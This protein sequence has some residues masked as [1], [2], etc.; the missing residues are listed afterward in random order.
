MSATVITATL[1][2]PRGSKGDV[3]TI[4]CGNCGGNHATVADVRACFARGPGAAMAADDAVPLPPDPG[5][6]VVDDDDPPP[7]DAQPARARALGGTPTTQNRPGSP[8]SAPS[9][10]ATPSRPGATRPAAPAPSRPQP[11]P[12]PARRA[13]P[14]ATPLPRPASAWAG[15]AELGRG[16]VVTPG[17]EAP[18]PWADAPVVTIDAAR[19]DPAAVAAVAAHWQARQRFVVALHGD[20]DAAVRTGAVVHEAPWALEPGFT[21]EAERLAALLGEHAVDGRD[22][23]AARFAPA[24]RAVA[25][26]AR[27]GDTTGPADVVLPD[28]HPAWVDGGPT[29]P[30]ALAHAVVPTVALDH[31]LLTPF[32]TAPTTAELAPDQLAAVAH[33]GGAARI[34][35]PAGSGKTRVLTERA[36]HLLGNWG[37]PPA[38]LCLVAFNVR[39]AEEMRSRTPDLP[40]L[41]IRTLNS[42]G[43]AIANGT[44][45]FLPRPDGR[46]LTT[47]DETEQRR[48]LERLVRFPRRAGTDPAAPWLEA[49]AAVRLGLQDPNAVE[50]AFDG[51][52]DGFA[53]VLPRYRAELAKGGL[54]DYDEQITEAIARLLA[55]P[56]ARAVAQRAGRLLLVDE[57]QDLAPAHLLLVRLLSAPRFD[58]FGVGDDDQTIY[59]YVGADPDWLVRYEHWFPGATS[60]AL[61][62]NYRCAPAVVTA[63]GNLL[64]RN[65]TRVA[66]A[67]RARPGRADEPG[68]LRIERTADPVRATL[69][70]VTGLVAAGVAPTDIA[71]L[72]RVNVT[73]LPVQLGLVAAGIPAT[74]AVDTTLL[75]RSG[76]RAALAWLRLASNPDRLA[77]GTVSDAARRPARG[78][79]PRVLDWMGE[80]NDLAGLR[81][82]AGRLT[83]PKD[84][85]KI[86]GFITDVQMLAALVERGADAADVLTAVRDQLGLGAAMDTLDRSRR[87]L[88]RS[89]HGD[90][91]AAMIDVAHLHPDASSFATWLQREL[92][93]ARTER[94]ANEQ[95]GVHLATVHRVKGREWPYVVVH[96]AND[97]LLPH[98]LAADHEEERRVFHV[99]ITRSSTATVVVADAGAPSP[100]L[101]ELAEPGQP[102][103][104]VRSSN[105][106]GAGAAVPAGPGAPATGSSGDPRITEA[107]K[108]WRRDRARRDSVPAYVVL[109]DKAIDD[110][111]KR[112]PDGLAELARCHG[113]GPTKLERYGDEILAAV[114]SAR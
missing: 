72:T 34:I 39:A 53:E 100:F 95:T 27:P 101:D 82:L 58:C 26:G 3:A 1:W 15:P 17:T 31:G 25:L 47:I 83:S 109:T 35:A 80:Q 68:D 112:R 11:A 20:L 84:A 23:A 114:Q 60:H 86:E 77:G 62:I 93:R 43:L 16:L 89:A 6:D 108:S 13:A 45:P 10:P 49:L 57:F 67:I 79:S 66:K 29:R 73:L 110:I 41:H 44:G 78:L 48:V 105:R 61:E 37:A 76:V 106:P 5:D 98:R 56:E 97:G 30:F 81:R 75:N 90:D 107:L 42:L 113:I 46:R 14:P 69:D 12:P 85:D 59:S 9:R 91:L 94:A 33:G 38:A 50:D 2:H 24:E 51:D 99:A 103:R 96:E 88:D 22:L 19:L 111:A 64:T 18:A 4:S 28:G 74:T 102:P 8:R 40:R 54:V 36:R 92:E 52:V 63:A 55:E 21:F 104:V 71:V 32:G 65:A 87:D 70:T 7:A